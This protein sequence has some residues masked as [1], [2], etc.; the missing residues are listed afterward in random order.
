MTILTTMI[1]IINR[2]LS[3]FST[4]LETCNMDEKTNFFVKCENKITNVLISNEAKEECP[5][6][7]VKMNWNINGLTFCCRH[8]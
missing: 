3:M 7:Y 1:I 4:M 6:D 5:P 2:N 8:S